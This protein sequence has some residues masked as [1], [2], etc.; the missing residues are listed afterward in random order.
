[1]NR[2]RRG[3]R[4]VLRADWAGS[5]SYYFNTNFNN[6]GTTDTFNIYALEGGVGGILL[7]SATID[8][9]GQGTAIGYGMYLE[10][11]PGATGLATELEG[12][13]QCPNREPWHQLAPCSS[14]RA[15]A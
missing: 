10:G 9:F 7:D 6:P 4:R 15:S 3:F 2:N 5:T 12:P 1:M 13:A 11:T 8:N 14:A